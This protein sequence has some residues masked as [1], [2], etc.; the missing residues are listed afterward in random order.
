M[1]VEEEEA[2]KKKAAEEAG[3]NQPTQPTSTSPTD[4]ATFRR[5][6]GGAEETLPDQIATDGR[7]RRRTPQ[8][9]GPTRADLKQ[10]D[11][12]TSHQRSLMEFD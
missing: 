1:F 11:D 5:G 8:G 3:T 2:A 7:G 9:E 12:T 4:Q 10:D 6:R